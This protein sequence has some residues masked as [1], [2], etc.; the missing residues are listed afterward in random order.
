MR[1]TRFLP[2]FAIAIVAACGSSG[3]QGNAG[4]AG[5]GGSGAGS[6]T[7]EPTGGSATST[8]TG[9][10]QGGS[11]ISTTSDGGGGGAGAGGGATGG[12]GQGGFT[13]V[14]TILFEN[15][16]AS[17][18][19]NQGY[20]PYIESMVAQGGLATNYFDSGTH[21]SLPNYLYLISG[22]TQYPGIIDVSPTNF[23]YFPSDSDHL[24][25]QLNTAGVKWRSY[26]EDMGNGGCNLDDT[27]NYAP[28]HDPF[29]Y[30]S[31]IQDDPTTCAKYNVDYSQ[32]AADLADG[33]YKYMWIT[34]NL[35]HDGHNRDDSFD[36]SNDDDYVVEVEQ[37]DEFLSQ[38][39]PKIQNSATYK[40]G[41]VIFVVWDEGANSVDDQVPMIVLSPK[42]KSAG[43][44]S[45]VKYTHANFLATIEDLFGL[46]RIG[47]AVGAANLYEFF[48]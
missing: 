21:P 23:L 25:K 37:A 29:L 15:H 26:Q 34:P 9:G 35:I 8:P 42:I 30:F 5:P 12:S 32:F 14:F 2:W 27:G 36:A 41:G 31:D 40:A 18:V 1:F 11:T 48:R 20:A 33:S 47:A 22:D 13:T 10:D 38:I 24:G 44:T 7:S 16:T 6:D 3:D 19:I 39:I 46:P 45:A 17:D 43:Y 4:G 28:R